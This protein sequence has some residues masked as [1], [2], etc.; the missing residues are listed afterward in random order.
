MF[1]GV[2]H[3][4]KLRSEHMDLAAGVR[5]DASPVGLRVGLHQT[6]CIIPII[7]TSERVQRRIDRLLD[8]A[9]AA[10]DGRPP[11]IEVAKT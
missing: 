8:Q 6:T 9:D 11:T 3:C 5:T 2:R 7:M 1:A 10:F 4:P